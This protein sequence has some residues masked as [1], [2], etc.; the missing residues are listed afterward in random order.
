M[1]PDIAKEIKE[2]LD[3][4]T[5]DELKQFLAR[6]HRINAA[7]SYLIY[8]FHLVQS[9]GILITSYATGNKDIKLIWA[10]IALNFLASLI[11]VY[12]KQNNSLLKKLLNDINS[13]RNGTYVDESEVVDTQ[14][15]QTFDMPML[16]NSSDSY[17][18]FGM[19]PPSNV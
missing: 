10:G 19:T 7:N 5:L 15:S 4:H 3:N 13:I 18:I 9:T 1:K 12:E 17:S 8:L 11:S 14:Q 2:I 6:R 16:N